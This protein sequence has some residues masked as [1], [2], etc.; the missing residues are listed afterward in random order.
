VKLLL[1]LKKSKVL[2]GPSEECF[3][4]SHSKRE[5]EEVKSLLKIKAQ[6]EAFSNLQHF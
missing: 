4:C 1:C 3:E 6:I 2:S 5:K